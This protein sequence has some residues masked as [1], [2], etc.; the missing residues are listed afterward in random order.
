MT[1]KIAID[2]P[3]GP[4]FGETIGSMTGT[5]TLIIHSTYGG[6]LLVA[7]YCQICSVQV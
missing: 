6:W 7:S 3:R 4:I 2:G 1:T 5:L